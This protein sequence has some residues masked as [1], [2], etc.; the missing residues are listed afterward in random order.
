[1]SVD[2]P[3]NFSNP[4]GYF[5]ERV[6]PGT[7]KPNFHIYERDN[8]KDYNNRV[9][10]SSFKLL[11]DIGVTNVLNTYTRNPS[12]IRNYDINL[13]GTFF[14]YDS[15]IGPDT[16]DNCDIA[17][18]KTDAF[19]F[20]R[21][22]CFTSN[23]QQNILN[24]SL[25]VPI[26]QYLYIRKDKGF[27]NSGS[28][29]DRYR[30]WAQYDE[31]T[32]PRRIP[33]R[34]ASGCAQGHLYYQKNEG[35]PGNTKDTRQYLSSEDFNKSKCDPTTDDPLMY[36][37]RTDF[38]GEII[39][40]DNYLAT[41]FPKFH[42]KN[43]IPGDVNSDLIR[44]RKNQNI[45]TDE[46]AIG[47]SA[48]IQ[49]V[50]NYSPMR[51]RSLESGVHYPSF[52]QLG[53]FIFEDEKC[54]EICIPSKD[55]SDPGDDN[56]CNYAY[57]RICAKQKYTPLVAEHCAK[58]SD[59]ECEDF[60][61]V[62]NCELDTKTKK[63]ID[64][65]CLNTV[66]QDNINTFSS[67]DCLGQ[68]SERNEFCEYKPEAPVGQQ[69][70]AKES[71]PTCVPNSE[72]YLIKFK[73]NPCQQE[74]YND[75]STAYDNVTNLGNGLCR[76][77][78]TQG[79]CEKDPTCS[80]NVDKCETKPGQ[81]LCNRLNTKK[82]CEETYCKWNQ[83]INRCTNKQCYMKYDYSSD[84]RACP[85]NVNPTA[86]GQA[87]NCT[88]LTTDN[89]CVYDVTKGND[90]SAK[91]TE[92]VPFDRKIYSTKN[93]L[94][95]EPECIGLASSNA[96]CKAF[97]KDDRLDDQGQLIGPPTPE[98]L[99]KCEK[100]KLD[101]CTNPLYYKN[102]NP[103]EDPNQCM[104]YYRR[105]GPSGFTAFRIPDF[106]LA[107]GE[108][109]SSTC[110]ERFKCNE[111][112][113]STE[114][115]TDSRCRFINGGCQV[116]PTE[117]D[118]VFSENRCGFFCRG[119]P[120]L[121]G[122]RPNDV[123]TNYCTSKKLDVCFP[124]DENEDTVFK[125]NS[126]WPKGW[127]ESDRLSVNCRNF[128]KIDEGSGNFPCENRERTVCSQMFDEW[129]EITGRTRENITWKEIYDTFYD[130][131]GDN[132]VEAS[133]DLCGCYAPQWVFD[134]FNEYIRDYL[135][136][137][138]VDYQN[139]WDITARP[140]CF[141]NI[142][143]R[144]NSVQTPTQVNADCPQCV[145]L[146]SVFIGGDATIDNGSCWLL[147]QDASCAAGRFVPQANAPECPDGEG[148]GGGG[149]KKGI[150]D[151]NPLNE[152]VE[153]V[154]LGLIALFL[155]MCIV[156][157]FNDLLAELIMPTIRSCAVKTNI[158]NY[159][160]HKL[161]VH[162]LPLMFKLIF[163]LALIIFFVFLLVNIEQKLD[164]I[165][166]LEDLQIDGRNEKKVRDVTR[167]TLLVVFCF[168][169][170]LVI[171]WYTTFDRDECKRTRFKYEL[172]RFIRYPGIA[173]SKFKRFIMGEPKNPYTVPT[174]DTAATF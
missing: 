41:V 140:Q 20:Q 152:K 11:P 125:E 87:S 45:Y 39:R 127:S 150:F 137:K 174:T 27:A 74:K 114:C 67:Q 61:N 97:T 31:E 91:Y 85:L 165:E 172:K 139:S 8:Y 2:F 25:K 73:E 159:E 123:E 121:A 37:Q 75:K 128:C 111:K 148:G 151:K 144:S 83:S 60:N 58:L 143:D 92:A 106:E 169:A 65:Y 70:R 43:N 77:Y 154:F 42:A 19:I 12:C 142:C 119:G 36:D 5:K 38:R 102:L 167:I 124:I 141:M 16:N 108:A 24:A 126:W 145:Q 82:K 76:T 30:D 104:D 53:D 26:G 10:T 29:E 79:F 95:D 134:K 118:D 1:M 34:I 166:P 32:Q 146:M 9:Y 155:C 13:A 163:G 55:A 132:F 171:L 66:N 135:D 50:D 33:E 122:Q 3:S 170:M 49:G 54:K 168:F 116:K 6:Q 22:S 105:D 113:T 84:E 94:T 86:C 103:N 63:D 69:C 15:N 7:I 17:S 98:S 156:F 138:G 129:L 117:C 157:Y 115:A 107:C 56:F 130:R 153:I 18:I 96:Y 136:D 162:Y 28:N 14:N 80:W 149:D 101:L 110:E 158:A 90:L 164:E 120:N 72:T 93:Y 147:Q 131:F 47:I 89:K 46:C 4:S 99:D 173:F 64:T 81:G 51:H 161:V 23:G 112:T 52:C 100:S 40:V 133:L 68:N 160:S 71:I 109:L 48:D 44:F 88:W 78:S 57:D 35:L 62:A 21:E 59:A